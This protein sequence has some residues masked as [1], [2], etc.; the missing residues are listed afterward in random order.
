MALEADTFFVPVLSVV[1][2]RFTGS[3]VVSYLHTTD[4]E[5]TTEVRHLPLF[6]HKEYW[7]AAGSVGAG[8]VQPPL[9]YLIDELG[10]V[11]VVIDLGSA[12]PISTTLD[13]LVKLR[14]AFVEKLGTR[15]TETDS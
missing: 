1:M 2:D 6:S 9:E 8:L 7:S 11:P 5:A 3:L 10:P 13:A 12:A 4:P 14:A 15:Q